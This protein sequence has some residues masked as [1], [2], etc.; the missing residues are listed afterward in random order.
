MKRD[1]KKMCR[2]KK[3]SWDD[4]FAITFLCKFF[5]FVKKKVF[6]SVLLFNLLCCCCCF[7]VSLRSL[8]SHS[9][10]HNSNWWKNTHTR[11][12]P[13]DWDGNHYC[14][15]KHAF[16]HANFSSLHRLLWNDFFFRSLSRAVK[17]SFLSDGNDIF[18]L[19]N[20]SSLQSWERERV[21]HDK[22]AA[23]EAI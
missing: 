7:Y 1:E 19:H 3:L 17:T 8:L 21:K 6:S 22:K 23:A 15:A 16:L 11:V 9:F 4:F 5:K 12:S 18:L 13:F 14:A 20:A 2:V 10:I